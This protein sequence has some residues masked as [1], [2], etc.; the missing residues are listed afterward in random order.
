MELK[1]TIK[2]LF[3]PTFEAVGDSDLSYEQKRSLLFNLYCFACAVYPEYVGA[4]PNTLFEYG[5]CFLIEPQ[6]HPDYAVNPQAFERA[7]A[8]SDALAVGGRWFRRRG[9]DFIKYDFGSTLYER[10]LAS[11]VI[12]PQDRAPI[13][14]LSLYAAVY[15]VCNLFKD[16]RPLWY[17][18]YF[19]LD[20]TNEPLDEEFDAQLCELLCTNDV[21]AA[22]ARVRGSQLIGDETELG[23]SVKL[24]NWYKPFID[25][26]RAH[27]FDVFEEQMKRGDAEFVAEYSTAMLSYYPENT[28][29]MNWNAASRT[30]CVVRSKDAA[31]LNTLVSDLRDYAAASGSATVEKYLKLAELMKK[32]IDGGA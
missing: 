26:R 25:W 8:S 1:D 3:E 24:Y 29:L 14:Q 21:Y 22:A 28:G 19:Y 4:P 10:M 9:E 12:P 2:E 17:T 5:C 31:A 11:G 27:I 32:N 20:A 30:E 13:P 16:L 23:G 7:A 6:R 18:Y 15:L